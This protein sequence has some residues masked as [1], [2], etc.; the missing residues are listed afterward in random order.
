M[1]RHGMES[2]RKSEKEDG[3]SKDDIKRYEEA[4]QKLTDDHV[5][6]VDEELKRKEAELLDV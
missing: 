6:T 3:V 5:G 4:M 2:L 1:R